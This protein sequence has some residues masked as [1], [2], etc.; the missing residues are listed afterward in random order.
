MAIV[1]TALGVAAGLA[2]EGLAAAL[3][4]PWVLG[5]FGVLMVLLALSMFGVYELQVPAALQTRLAAASG[6][7]AGGKLARRVQWKRHPRGGATRPAA[8]RSEP[9]ITGAP[10]H[11][12]RHHRA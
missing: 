4:N 8:H 5:T 6:R 9:S 2:G 3:Q 10:P 7:R 1:Y 11:E 12:P